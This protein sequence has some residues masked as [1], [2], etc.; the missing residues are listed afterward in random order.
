MAQASSGC[1]DP[2]SPCTTLSVPHCELP[3]PFAYRIGLIYI[4]Y[5]KWAEATQNQIL[6]KP[7]GARLNTKTQPAPGRAECWE[8]EE[9][10]RV[11]KLG[12]SIC[13]ANERRFRKLLLECRVFTSKPKFKSSP[14]KQPPRPA[15]MWYQALPSYVKWIGLFTSLF[16]HLKKET[17]VF[18]HH[19]VFYKTICNRWE[20]SIDF[21]FFPWCFS[22]KYWHWVSSECGKI[23]SDPLSIN[24]VMWLWSWMEW[25]CFI[26]KDSMKYWKSI[27]RI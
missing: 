8:W 3:L 9:V 13:T 24:L 1:R 6:Q 27:L 11:P 4:A 7:G 22:L 10:L 18:H 16:I 12:R 19:W 17:A 20:K 25:L 26:Q 14:D 21:W 5:S 23:V 2:R 15:A